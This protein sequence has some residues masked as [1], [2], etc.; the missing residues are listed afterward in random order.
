MRRSSQANSKKNVSKRVQHGWAA[1]PIWAFLC[2][3]VSEAV[4][5]FI[6]SAG[7]VHE[8]WP[9]TLFFI[10]LVAVL[11]SWMDRH[12][13]LRIPGLSALIHA[14]NRLAHQPRSRKIGPLILFLFAVFL[15]HSIGASV[16][17]EGVVILVTVFIFLAVRHEKDSESDEIASLVGCAFAAAT[18]NVVAG[19]LLAI[20]TGDL[21]RQTMLRT[22]ALYAC[23]VGIWVALGR[24]F[25][26]FQ[27]TVHP[28]NS[29][30]WTE[31]S[32]YFIA[33][34]IGFTAGA[35]SFLFHLIVKKLRSFLERVTRPQAW[36]FLIAVSLTA[37]LAS[38]WGVTSQ[39]L[40]VEGIRRF[41]Q[42]QALLFEP[43]IKT[44]ATAFSIGIG[45]KGGEYTPLLWIGSSLGSLFSGASGSRLVEW[46]PLGFTASQLAALGFGGVFAQASRCPLASIALVV[47]LGGWGTLPFA[48]L[49]CAISHSIGGT[50]SLYLIPSLDRWRIKR[51]F[52]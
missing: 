20:E 18:G 49:V 6:E 44:I 42:A 22:F 11:L 36:I 38:P 35:L 30:G 46:M 5:R 43:L 4:G 14:E 39:G 50:D 24:S 27:S 15:S 8:A 41:F 1:I 7:Q 33:V 52:L 10:P 16:G 34:A 21:K 23:F 19:A 48:I 37:L 40:G 3:L 2:I 12:E 13:R 28:T 17:R 9:Q 25:P 31:F 47:G 29:L 45:L 26:F 51:Y 32:R